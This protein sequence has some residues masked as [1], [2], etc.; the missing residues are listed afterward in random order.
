M[1]A[2]SII[3]S[4]D[5]QAISQAVA[6]LHDGLLVAFPTETVYGL[7]GD[8]TRDQS[9]AAIFAAKNRP[10]FNPLII[11]FPD[12]DAAESH[13]VFDHRS[14]LLAQK[15]WPGPLTLVLKRKSTSPVS[16]LA[17]AGLDTLAVRVP[18]ASLART[19]LQRSNCPI[20]APSANPSG[21]ISPTTAAHVATCLGEKVALILD[22]GP[23]A[24]GLESSVVDV[25]GETPVLLRPGSILASEIAT[26]T[27]PLSIQKTSTHPPRSPGC[28]SRHYAPC[29]PVRLDATTLH[30]GEAL[31]SFG[32]HHLTGCVAERNL[33]P[34][35]NLHEAAANLFSMLRELDNSN[36]SGIA[37]MPIPQ[38]DL[39]YA[40]NDRLRRAATP[41][42][43]PS[44]P[45]RVVSPA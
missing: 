15:F 33:S 8:A 32:P 9:V 19:L 21:R 36:A 41:S 4:G 23:C 12:A 5:S 17:A 27:G 35:G 43:P 22:G 45:Q 13:V 1:A 14:R 31:L 44:S 26:L 42:D 7:G 25:S 2:G 20:A 11:H 6:A 37:V 10:H 18:A 16:L 29:L 24:I 38:D 34:Q 3:R 39:G 28:L 30:H 40:I